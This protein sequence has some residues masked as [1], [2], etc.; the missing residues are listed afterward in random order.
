[1]DDEPMWAIDRVVTLTPSFEITIPETANE[2]AIKGNHLTLIKEKEILRNCHGHNLSKGD[3]I[4][5]FYRGLNEITQEVLNATASGSKILHSIEGTVLEE[6]IFFE[7]DKFIAMTADENYDSESDIEEP[8]FEKYTI[9]RDYKIK[10]SLEEPPTV[11]ELKPLPDNLEYVFL[12]ELSFLHV[13]ISSQLSAQK[14]KLESALKKH[15]KAFAW[16]TTYILGI[17]PSFYVVY[18]D[19]KPEPFQINVTID[20]PVDIMDQT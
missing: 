19:M 13:I 11:L 14:N 5:I 3:I 8:P 9:N 20:Q 17:C 10:T 1:M 6:E 7:F 15:K 12:E 4:K 2:F 16:K 18:L